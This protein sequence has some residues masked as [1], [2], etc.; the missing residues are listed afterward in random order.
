MVPT[1]MSSTRG[2][3][4]PL[5]SC[6]PLHLILGPQH[7]LTRAIFIHY[8]TP[9]SEYWFQGLPHLPLTFIPASASSLSS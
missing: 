9:V 4:G 2:I 8:Q 1:R 7:N 3:P 5:Q 6:F